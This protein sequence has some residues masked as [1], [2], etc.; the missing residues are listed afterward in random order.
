MLPADFGLKRPRQV[1]GLIKQEDSMPRLATLALTFAF[2]V[3]L[4]LAGP[5]MRAAA[6]PVADNDALYTLYGRVF[7]DPHGCIKGA[8]TASPYAKGNV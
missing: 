7:P 2:V 3:T 6:T 8:P 1:R 4:V 5:V